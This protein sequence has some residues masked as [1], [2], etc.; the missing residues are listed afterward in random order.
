MRCRQ[1]RYM[2]GD[3]RDAGCVGICGGGG[4]NEMQ[5]V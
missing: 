4:I 3:R 2:W 1:C 5:A